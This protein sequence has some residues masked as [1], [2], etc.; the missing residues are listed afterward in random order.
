MNSGHKTGT[1]FL[2]A[3]GVAA[4][5][6]S[7]CCLGP[8]ILVLLG[9]SGAWIG[10]L[11]VLEPYRPLFLGVTSVA[12]GLA[13]WR[14]FRPAQTC[15]ADRTCSTPGSRNIQKI[16]FS[17]VAVLALVAFVFPYYARFFY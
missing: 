3:G 2:A 17:I 6:A 5:L 16:L 13:A 11:S 14:I 10:S 7:A 1:G 12:L 8:L 9:F 4:I 15:E